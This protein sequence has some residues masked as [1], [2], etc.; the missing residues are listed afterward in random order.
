[1]SIGGK[2]EGEKRDVGSGFVND[3]VSHLA[4]LPPVPA[5]MYT[6]VRCRWSA[7]DVE[8]GRNDGA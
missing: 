1:V 5:A 4:W 6:A 8:V 3:G 2:E 7:G